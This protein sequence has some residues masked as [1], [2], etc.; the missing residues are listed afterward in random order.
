[1]SHAIPRAA[2]WLL[3]LLL[4]PV[5]PFLIWGD[6]LEPWVAATIAETD[7]PALAGGAILA[8]TSDILLPI[9]SSMV[10]TLVGAR[11]SLPT[12]VLINWTGLM[13]GAVVGFSL[14]RWC[15]GAFVRRISDADDLARLELLAE[16]H[17]PRTLVLTR[18][19]PILAE[20]TVLIFGSARMPWRVFL[21]P[22]ALG[23]LG[24][25]AI[26]AALGHWART[27][28]AELWA[29]VASIAVPL[30]ATIAARIFWKSARPH[31]S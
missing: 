26:Y 22:V 12:A 27:E 30:A 14:A 28:N 19:L 31:E 9:P 13:L 1:M 20:A 29:L 4:V 16:R 17:G 11:F 7:G 3:A 18:A 15:G 2:W 24:I 21:P 10:G 23:N 5:V 6:R 8:Q 25:A